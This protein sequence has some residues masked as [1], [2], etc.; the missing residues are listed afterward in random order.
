MGKRERI[1]LVVDDE[2]ATREA[3][4]RVLESAGYTVHTASGGKEALRVADK[5]PI[6]LVISDYHMPDMTGIEL[7]MLLR[8][9][10]PNI[11]RIMV[12]GQ[13]DKDVVVRSIVRSI[14]DGEV[15]RFIQKPWDNSV[16]RVT[17]HFAFETLALEAE[18]RRLLAAVRRQVEFAREMEKALPGIAELTPEE[19]EA[20]QRLK[21]KAAPG[22]EPKR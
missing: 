9:R 13:A 17:V 11:C 1:I 3:L 12:T 22:E 14:N 8:E 5:Q 4:A 10:H 2:E 7:F 6:E 18:N 15:Y 21:P 16:L 20:L 19:E